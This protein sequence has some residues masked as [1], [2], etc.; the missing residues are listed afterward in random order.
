[1][2][3]WEKEVLPNVDCKYGA[4]MG[5]GSILPSNPEEPI[6]LRL[7]RMPLY[8]GDYDTGGAYWGAPSWDHPED[9]I[10]VAW[11]YAHENLDQFLIR[12]TCRARDRAGAKE[13][14]QEDLPNARFHR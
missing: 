13:K 7:R 5:R 9:R 6:K 14:I 3:N 12:V 8:D 10:W 11:S 4:P 1:M 2:K